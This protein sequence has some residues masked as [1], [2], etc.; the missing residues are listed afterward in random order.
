MGRNMG[1]EHR[2][3]TD[4]DCSVVLKFTE[5]IEFS[6]QRDAQ[7]YTLQS[8]DQQAR[9]GLYFGSMSFTNISVVLLYLTRWFNVFSVSPPSSPRAPPPEPIPTQYFP[10]TVFFK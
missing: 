3:R 4:K 9:H 5:K 10:P 2:K 7:Q 8:N 1:I 6:T